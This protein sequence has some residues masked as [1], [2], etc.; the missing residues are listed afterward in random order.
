M[1]PGCQEEHGFNRTC[2]SY[3]AFAVSLNW[4]LA[5]WEVDTSGLLQY[6]VM[7]LNSSVQL[8]RISRIRSLM[9]SINVDM[10][11]TSTAGDLSML[12]AATTASRRIWASTSWHRRSKQPPITQLTCNKMS[13]SMTLRAY[14]HRQYTLCVSNQLAPY[15]TAVDSS[16]VSSQCLKF[17]YLTDIPQKYK[18]TNTN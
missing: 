9:Q 2:S 7:V 15:R 10:L 4:R 11:E 16:V 14:E 1:G 17:I 13:F 3:Q 12:I 6:Q 18:W 5:R 8:T